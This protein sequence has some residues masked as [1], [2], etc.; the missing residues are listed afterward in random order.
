MSK[1]FLFENGQL[2]L[3]PF[4]QV[5]LKGKILTQWFHLFPSIHI[6]LS[7][8]FSKQEVITGDNE[9]RGDNDDDSN[10]GTQ[11]IYP[12]QEQ[13]DLLAKRQLRRRQYAARDPLNDDDEDDDDDEEDNSNN[14]SGFANTLFV[15]FQHLFRDDP[16]LADAIQGEFCRFEMPLRRAVS[17]FIVD[18]HPILNRYIERNDSGGTGQGGAGSGNNP[19]DP[20]VFFVAFF[21]VNVHTQM[22]S[23]RTLRTDLVGSLVSL[24]GTITRTSEVRPELLVASFRCDKCGLLAEKIPQ[25]YHFT[26][27]TLCR[28]PRCKNKSPMRFALEV[29]RSEFVDWQKLRVQESANQI[30]PGSMPRSMDVILRN[31]MVERCKAG[32]KCV[33]WAPLGPGGPMGPM[34]PMGPYIHKY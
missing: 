1:I 12:Y 18:R 33:F 25:H 7:L 22:K 2:I 4:I 31:E 11:F 3:A 14:N 27:P 16:E 20:L 32:D 6:P 13:A 10:M 29:T 23:I 8:I 24:Q 28:N 5:P 15:N 34:G 9:Q 26:R 19:S 21:N 17:G 30:P